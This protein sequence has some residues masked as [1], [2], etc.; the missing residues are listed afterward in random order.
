[1]LHLLKKDYVL[2]INDNLKGILQQGGMFLIAILF[3]FSIRREWISTYFVAQYLFIVIFSY[4]TGENQDANR[5]LFSSLP[6][7]RW[8]IIA[9]P[10]V[11]MIAI[12]GVCFILAMG[13]VGALNL[14]GVGI[15]SVE[16]ER[17]LLVFYGGVFVYVATMN[18]FLYVLP[19]RWLNLIPA[20]ILPIMMLS[21][22]K[23]V[24]IDMH[25][26][27]ML[28]TMSV[29]YVMLSFF[30]AYKSINA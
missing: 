5:I 3:I 11:E 7:E 20:M 9:Y 30:I 23:F 28:V 25:I 1:M 13:M 4:I 19:K 10:Y 27:K 17:A 6:I 22:K 26:L 14:L 16:V 2:Y 24:H 12:S 21:F 8:K 18:L 15:A 29:L